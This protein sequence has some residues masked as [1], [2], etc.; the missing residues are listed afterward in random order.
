MAASEVAGCRRTRPVLSTNESMTTNEPHSKDCI[1]LEEPE[2]IDDLGQL[3]VG[4][5]VLIDER[6]RPQTVIATGVREKGLE[7]T[8]IHVETPVVRVQGHWVGAVPTDLRHK[9]EGLQVTDDGEY[10]VEYQ[11]TET[12]VDTD[13][14][15]SKDVR[16]THIVGS[17][18]RTETDPDCNEVTA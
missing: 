4:D 17:Q 2:Q 13:V 7:G 16:R 15:R 10:E 9:L 12:I 8:D 14:G 1:E 3:D 5:R 18:T 11:E 6:R